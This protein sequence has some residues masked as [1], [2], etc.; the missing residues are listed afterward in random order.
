MHPSTYLVILATAAM[1]TAAPNYKA[2]PKTHTKHA[3]GNTC[4]QNQAQ[5]CCNSNDGLAVLGIE[6]T[7]S[8]VCT[9]SLYYTY[10][11]LLWLSCE[12]MRYSEWNLH[13]QRPV[14]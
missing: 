4:G 13:R 1:T 12:L 3:S 6:C 9:S 2:T 8:S 14:L 5:A 11:P 10:P 7:L